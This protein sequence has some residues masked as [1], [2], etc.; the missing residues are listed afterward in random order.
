MLSTEF[1]WNAEQYFNISLVLEFGFWMANLIF[2]SIF[3]EL[4]RDH[5]CVFFWIYS[6]LWNY[7]VIALKWPKV[8]LMG[9]NY[10]GKYQE[11][12]WALFGMQLCFCPGL[13]FAK[14]SIRVSLNQTLCWIASLY[15]S[16]HW[17]VKGEQKSLLLESYGPLR[18]ETFYFIVFNSTNGKMPRGTDPSL[19]SQNVFHASSLASPVR[20]PL[21]IKAN[22]LF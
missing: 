22:S 21:I 10:N 12:H 9:M 6:Q 18:R 15:S 17:S 14:G 11:R 3:F 20:A 13:S 4:L 8:P 19:F 5:V 2:L 1:K 16:M 7:N